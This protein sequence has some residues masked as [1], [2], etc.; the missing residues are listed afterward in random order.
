M[1]IWVIFLYIFDHSCTFMLNEV[2]DFGRKVHELNKIQLV[3][4]SD[5]NTT[6]M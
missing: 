6:F 1:V 5:Y 3:P 2:S 4:L